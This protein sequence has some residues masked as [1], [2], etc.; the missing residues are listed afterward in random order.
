MHRLIA[1]GFALALLLS[2]VARI[3]HADPLDDEA[4]KIGKQLQCPICS[5]ATVA[6]SPSDLAG[7]MR[8]VI[9]A[10]LEAGA[11]DQ[12]IIDYFVERYGDGVLI[13]PPRRGISL[14]VWIA[15]VAILLGGGLLLWRLLR[16][17]LRPRPVPISS[18]LGQPA[19]AYR[20]GTTHAAEDAPS[21]A[22]DRARAELDR[23]RREG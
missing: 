16:T 6:D 22:V 15:P 13:E 5:G 4:R 3:A 12:Q 14:L 2:A 8:G 11:S 9:R 23:F 20:N 10:K 18:R 7:Q 19:P 1:V 21:L 17:W